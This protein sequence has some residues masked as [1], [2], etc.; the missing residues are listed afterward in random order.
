[1]QLCFMLD[2]GI[3]V[4]VPVW[5][6]TV[7]RR[8]LHNECI[9]E[10]NNFEWYS[11]V[12]IWFCLLYDGQIMW[13]MTCFMQSHYMFVC[14]CACVQHSSVK[15]CVL[16]LCICVC[17]CKFVQKFVHACLHELFYFIILS[18]YINKTVR[19]NNRNGRYKTPLC[20][21][22]LPSIDSAEQIV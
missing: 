10:I 22:M 15:V 8:L 6:R 7:F 17:V 21:N 5:R 9:I 11:F 16:S 4:L 20:K 14:G 19:Y 18:L 13:F 2:A 1:M 3:Y 12:H